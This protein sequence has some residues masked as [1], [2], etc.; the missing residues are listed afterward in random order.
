MTI[1]SYV[2]VNHNLYLQN[3]ISVFFLGNK[4]MFEFPAFCFEYSQTARIAKLQIFFA[5][6]VSNE[7]AESLANPEKSGHRVAILKKSSFPRNSD[8][9]SYKSIC[10][11]PQFMM[12]Y[13]MPRGDESHCFRCGS[14]YRGI[15]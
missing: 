6:E 2:K 8:E 4:A 12:N 9:V 3:I 7:Q 15:T 13:E 11:Q 10:I 14:G 1:E 5:F